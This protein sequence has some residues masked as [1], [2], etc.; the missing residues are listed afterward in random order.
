MAKQVHDR[1]FSGTTVDTGYLEVIAEQVGEDTTFAKIIELVEEAQESKAKTQKFLDKFA[2]YYTP[3]MLLLAVLVYFVSRNPEL[4]LTFLVIACP[5]ALVISAPVSMVAGLGNGAANGLLVKGGEVLENLAKAD[6]VVFDKT[7]TL[8]GRK[9]RRGGDHHLWRY[10]GTRVA[11][12]GGRGRSG[13]GASARAGHRE[14]RE[15]AARGTHGTPGA[16]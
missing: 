1:V 9:T 8:D 6:L 12:I 15:G 16:G 11:R 3:G 5:G 2:S 14:C 4:A 10:P 7:G 13:I